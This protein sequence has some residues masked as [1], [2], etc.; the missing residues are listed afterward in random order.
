[1]EKS[2]EHSKNVSPI[3]GS[4]LSKGLFLVGNNW[5]KFYGRKDT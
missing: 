4:L 3:T 2:C 5:E 1:M